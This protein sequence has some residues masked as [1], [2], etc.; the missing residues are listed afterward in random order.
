MTQGEAVGVGRLA[1]I[2]AA[3]AAV[4]L[5][6][7]TVAGQPRAWA[8]WLLA[9]F[10]LTTAG[11]AGIVFVAT[12]YAAGASWSVAF[13]R[14]PEALAATLPLGAAAVVALIGLATSAYPWAGHHEFHG[15]SVAQFKA[16]WLSRPFFTGRAIVYVFVW[17]AFARAI[18][19]NSRSQD[20][21]GDVEYS[22]RNTRLS[23]AFL[24]AF[25][26]TFSLASFDW[27]MSLEPEWYS[28]IFA[29]YNFAGLFSSGLA[30]IVLVAVRLRHGPLARVLCDEHLHDLGKLLFAFCTFWMYI[31]FSQYMLIWY[32]NIPEETTYYIARAHGAYGP[33][34]V[35]NVVLNWVVPFF[36][37]LRRGPKR[38]ATLI[39][40]VAVV[41]LIGRWLDLYLMIVPPF[42]PDG[43]PFGVWEVA[44]AAALGGGTVWAIAR[45]L[46]AASLV[47]ARDPRLGE[48][49]HYHV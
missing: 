40:R 10:G 12:Q 5:V 16:L 25:A 46:R 19:A 35:A 21:R 32:A 17:M 6:G 38:R 20:A 7:G 43:P 22:V 36:A 15:G 26:V 23:I 34:F 13:R 41:V 37:L 45:G 1:G 29:M 31:W 49:L 44:G 11:L 4:V 28:T 2:V 30:I 42:A 18:I 48:S 3:A 47:P 14:V 8:G 27:I 33:V 24:W 9:S 39:A